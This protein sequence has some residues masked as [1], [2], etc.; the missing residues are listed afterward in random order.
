VPNTFAGGR[1]GWR[2]AMANSDVTSTNFTVYAVC[3]LATRPQ[4][5]CRAGWRTGSAAARS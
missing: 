4:R 1:T 5:R 2:V 3:R